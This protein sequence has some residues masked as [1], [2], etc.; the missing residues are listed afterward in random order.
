MFDNQWLSDYEVEVPCEVAPVG[1]P[2]D[3]TVGSPPPPWWGV[4]PA[5]PPSSYQTPVSAS[6]PSKRVPPWL[7]RVFA[8]IVFTALTVVLAHA[9]ESMIHWQ[10]ADTQIPIQIAAPP[11]IDHGAFAIL[12]QV[13]DHRRAAA[14]LNRNPLLSDPSS[15]VATP[16]SLT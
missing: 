14:Y 16:K 13:R 12:L 11:Q 5:G 1:L 2:P 9:L 15:T 6:P 3:P 10:P 8:A 4:P 7:T